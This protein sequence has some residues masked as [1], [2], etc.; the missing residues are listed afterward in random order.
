MSKNN[1]TYSLSKF[2]DLFLNYNGFGNINKSTIHVIKNK[3]NEIKLCDLNSSCIK[4]E[5]DIKNKNIFSGHIDIFNS[6]NDLNDIFNVQVISVEDN[7]I[8]DTDS[9]TEII[10]DSELNDN[11]NNCNKSIQTNSNITNQDNQR[12]YIQNKYENFEEISL[13]DNTNFDSS[14]IKKISTSENLKKYSEDFIQELLNYH[15]MIILFILILLI[16]FLRK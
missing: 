1:D 9:D 16:Y 3:K 7:D 2:D 13:K 14:K 6:N 5:F 10:T 4:I 12:Y 11:S 15:T 8:Y